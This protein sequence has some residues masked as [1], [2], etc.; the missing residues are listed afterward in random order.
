M[1]KDVKQ[2]F[3]LR[4]TQA[5][6]TEMIVILYDMTL[7]YIEEAK[8]AD[9]VGDTVAYREGIRKIRACINELIQSL[10]LEYEIAGNLY[11]LYLFC[12]RRLAYAEV[13]K[14][15]QVLDEVETVIVQLRDAYAQIAPQNTA[16]PVMSNTETVYAGLTYGKG[17]LTKDMTNQ[18][19]NRG[20]LV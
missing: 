12:I 14:D 16:A 19:P 15:A 4:I 8:E 7:M 20:M 10:H 3:T 6:A 1:T 11:K 18:S 5:N 2:Q 9:S 13:R 17:A